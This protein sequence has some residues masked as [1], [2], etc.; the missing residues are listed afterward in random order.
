MGVSGKST[1][2]RPAPTTT[3]KPA[4]TTRANRTSATAT[5]GSPG[6]RG[7]PAPAPVASGRTLHYAANSNFDS[8]GN[9]ILASLGFNLADV[10]SRSLVDLL[11]SGVRGLVYLGS[12]TPAD[13]AFKASVDKY[14]G[15]AKLYGFYL[16]DEP[17]PSSCPVANLR[18]EA[19]YIRAKFPNAVTFVLIQ[20]TDGSKA[21]TFTDGYTP[22]NLGVDLIGLDPYPCRTELK[23]CDYAMIGRYVTAANR[24]GIPTSRIVPVFQAFGGGEY[25]DDGGGKWTL[26]TADQARRLLAE[27][28]EAV[29]HPAFDFVY[30]WGS[31]RGTTALSTGPASLREVFAAHNR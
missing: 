8:N 17:E 24:A 23:G 20:N 2:R 25:N 6:N 15:A 3:S 10:A 4:P 13:A 5:A 14:A 18:S 1:S 29:P 26:P 28:A 31:Q 11:P 16:A 27:W 7:A 9:Y 30:S 19:A 12:C 22:A 21:P